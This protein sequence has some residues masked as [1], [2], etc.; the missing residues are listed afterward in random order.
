MAATL[1]GKSMR[2]LFSLVSVI[3]MALPGFVL[4]RV[5]RPAQRLE[6]LREFILDQPY[7]EQAAASVMSSQFPAV[8]LT[9]S[10]D[11]INFEPSG[12][13]AAGAA[14]AVMIQDSCPDSGCTLTSLSQSGFTVSGVVPAV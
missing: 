9:A 3:E 1:N 10:V 11:V 7:V 4:G 12:G 2:S 5:T 13:S 8:L 6:S 14:R